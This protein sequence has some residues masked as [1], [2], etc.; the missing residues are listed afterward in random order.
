MTLLPPQSRLFPKLGM[1]TTC[2]SLV[3]LATYSLH[4]PADSATTLLAVTLAT[5]A[6]NSF[7]IF[8]KCTELMLALRKEKEGTEG[9]RQAGMRFGILHGVSV[10]LAFTAIGLGLTYTGILGG[11]VAG[12][13]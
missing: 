1:V 8:G 10:T 6:L 2:A 12:H 9:R 11:R 5:N 13:W 7:Y 3:T 4:H